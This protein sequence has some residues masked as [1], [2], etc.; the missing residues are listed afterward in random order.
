MLRG[1]NIE[2]DCS[3]ILLTD[4]PGYF[5]YTFLKNLYFYSIDYSG[6]TTE[7]TKN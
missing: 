5:Y 2:L 6:T 3:N 7:V 4:P 1:L